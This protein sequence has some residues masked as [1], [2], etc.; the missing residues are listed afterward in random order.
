ML[1]STEKL[2]ENAEKFHL[3]EKSVASLME[4]HKEADDALIE[5]LWAP[6]ELPSKNLPTDMEES[7]KHIILLYS[8]VANREKMEALYREKNYSQTMLNDV[9]N[10]LALWVDKTFRDYGTEGLGERAWS[11]AKAIAKGN[12]LQFGRLQCEPVHKFTGNMCVVE[13]EG[14]KVFIPRDE[15]KEGEKIFFGPGDDAINIHI[16][17]SGPLLMEEC[18]KSFRKIAEFVAERQKDYNWKGFMFYS[19]ILDPFFANFNPESNLA[20]LQK[21]GPIYDLKLDQR[22]EVL[23]RVFHLTGEKSNALKD[24]SLLPGNTSMERA[25][26]D[27]LQN[28]GRFSEYAMV[29]LREG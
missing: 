6:G 28:G 24:Y 17:A 1:I 21:L 27:H 13:R 15:V 10:D 25:V 22:N 19:W 29:V 2:L 4:Y 8:I 26:R 3:T 18:Q 16:P 23:W 5:E 11:W 9:S 7:K 12:V 14:K 20:K